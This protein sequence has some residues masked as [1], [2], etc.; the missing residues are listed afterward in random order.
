MMTL[1]AG[2]QGSR[3]LSLRCGGWWLCLGIVYIVNGDVRLLCLNLYLFYSHVFV[4]YFFYS[5]LCVIRDV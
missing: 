5:R 2:E 1:P 3:A 4:L